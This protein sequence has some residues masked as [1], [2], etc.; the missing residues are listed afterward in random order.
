MNLP[1]SLSLLTACVGVPQN[2]KP[3]IYLSYD[4]L[5][6]LGY[7]R[8]VVQCQSACSTDTHLLHYT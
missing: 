1:Y 7:V 6:N 8:C 4:A 5:S 2:L 3:I